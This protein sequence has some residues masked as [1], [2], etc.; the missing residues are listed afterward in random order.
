MDI[1]VCTDGDWARIYEFYRLT[2]DAG[3]TYSFPPN[4]TIDEARPWWMEPPPG[5]T[6]VALDGQEI[7]GSAKMGPNRPGRGAHI[8]TAAFLVDPNHQGRGVGRALGEYMINWAREE[9]YHGIQFNA[10]VESNH[11]A[12]HLW[13]SLGFEII[14]TVPEAFDHPDD[15]LVG[16]HVMYQRLR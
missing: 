9:G 13:Q 1:R 4:Q 6:V 2:M 16:L 14:G 15:G 7:I 5:Q 12:V 3:R 10:V 11:P 8:A